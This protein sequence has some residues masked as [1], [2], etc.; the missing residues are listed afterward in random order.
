MSEHSR[1]KTTGIIL[2]AGAFSG[3]GEPKQLLDAGGV[4]LP[5]HIPRKSL[6]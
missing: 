1:G 2:A 5:D 4:K 3:M 6:D